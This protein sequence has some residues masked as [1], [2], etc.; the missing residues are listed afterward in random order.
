[1]IRVPRIQRQQTVREQMHAVDLT[2][3]LDDGLMFPTIRHGV[4][5]GAGL[6]FPRRGHGRHAQSIRTRNAR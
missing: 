1:M 5:V 6:S 3:L 2:A 4:R